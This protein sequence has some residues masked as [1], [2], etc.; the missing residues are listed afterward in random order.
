MNNKSRG[1][2]ARRRRRFRDRFSDRE[3]IIRTGE[4]SRV[5][6]IGKRTQ[7]TGVALGATAFALLIGAVGVFALGRH[8]MN[9]ERTRLLYREAQVS[10]EQQ[11]I[12]VYRDQLDE[13]TD[14]LEKRQDVIEEMI[15]MLPADTRDATSGDEGPAQS[16][17]KDQSADKHQSA[18]KTIDGPTKVSA[19]LPE[20]A[21]L[22]LI[23]RR[24]LAS[25]DR[26]TRF[27]DDRATKAVAAIRRIGLDPWR[28]AVPAEAAMGGPLRELVTEADGSLDPRFERLGRSLTRMASLEQGLEGIPRVMPTDLARMTSNFGYRRDPFTGQ[29][30]LHSGLDFGGGY[31]EP[32]HAAADGKVS[33][34]GTRGGYGKVVEITHGNGLL[35]RY[36]HM[37]GW[38]AQVGQDVDAGEVIGAIGSTGRSTGPHLHFEVRIGGRAVNPRPFLEHAAD[39]I[40]QARS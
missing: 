35:T 14:R 32:V 40:A 30:A 28:M 13:M 1:E 39:L 34:V 17:R 19:V 31:G 26:L 5:V 10:N 20:A 7:M 4:R 3:L 25:V 38:K 27:A 11:Q 12:D 24:Q 15:G 16:T 9:V 29:A 2:N 21:Q 37:S 33:F 36:A 18:A 22:S 6:A 8:D 23:E